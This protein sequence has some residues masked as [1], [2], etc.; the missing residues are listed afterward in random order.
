MTEDITVEHAIDEQDIPCNYCGIVMEACM[1]VCP[2]FGNRVK[3]ECCL[4]DATTGL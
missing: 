2:S 3:C 4:L 1:C